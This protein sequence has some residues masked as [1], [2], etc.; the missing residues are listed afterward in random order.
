MA[1]VYDSVGL[2][3]DPNL[4]DFKARQIASGSMKIRRHLG[5][6]ALSKY[7]DC[8]GTQIGA[9][10]D[11]YEIMLSVTTRLVPLPAGATGVSTVVE[12]AGKPLNFPQAY[13]PCL[14]T[15]RLER[16]IGE[17]ARIKVR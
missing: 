6:A 7:L 15:G 3:I 9:S 13:T 17:V 1:A 14:S 8:G 16:F 12:A 5:E 10:A 2:T 4:M 11:S